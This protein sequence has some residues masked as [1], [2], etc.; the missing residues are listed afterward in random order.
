MK[1]TCLVDNNVV[2]GRL[3]G[4]HG[5]SLLIESREKR[6]LY[7]CGESGHEDLRDGRASPSYPRSRTRGTAAPGEPSTPAS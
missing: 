6:V 3:W 2:D 1:I 7:D 4:E 5:L